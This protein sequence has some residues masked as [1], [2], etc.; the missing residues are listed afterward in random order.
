MRAM[1]TARAVMT[2]PCIG[3]ILPS[4]GWMSIGSRAVDALSELIEGDRSVVLV[5]DSKYTY[6]A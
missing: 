4:S 3:P 5:A 1:I 2:N 6:E